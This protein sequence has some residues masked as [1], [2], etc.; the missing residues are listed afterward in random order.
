MK[1]IILTLVVVLYAMGLNAQGTSGNSQKKNDLP[2]I[3]DI[4]TFFGDP[5]ISGAQLS[6][7]GKY[8]S[9]RKPYNGIAN[10]W[11]KKID[12]PFESAK[13]V[14]A[15]IKRPVNSYFWSRD[16]K[17]ILYVQ[18]L[19][20]DENYRVYSVDPMASANPQ[21]GV[22]EAKDLTP[23]EKVRVYILSVPKTDP[24]NI[25]IGINDRDASYHDIYKL[26]IITGERK[27]ILQNNDKIAGFICD[28]EGVVRLAINTNE[29]G[30]QELLSYQNGK[31][32]KIY[33]TNSEE[34]FGFE[35]FLKDKNFGYLSSNKGDVD[36]TQ[37]Y[38][39]NLTNGQTTFMESDPESEVDLESIIFS[40]KEKK[41]IA[42]TY[43]G[44]RTRYYFKDSDWQNS[45]ETMKSKLP[46]G[47]VRPTSMTD[48]EMIWLVYVGSDV[49]PGSIYVFNRKTNEVSLLFNS[50]PELK[51]EYLANMEP[52]KFK[53]RDGVLIPGYIA[54]P[55][56][57]AAKN[58]PTVIFPHGG[59][60]ARDNWGFNVFVQFLAN[61]GYAVLVPNFR[62]STGYGKK[63][64]N[65]GNKQWGTGTMQHDLSDGVKYMIDRGIA[66]PQKVAIMG[67]SYGGYATLA[68]LA[69]TPE[70]YAAGVDI[71]G[72]SNLVTLLKT[73]PAYWE[74]FRKIMA[75]RLGDLNIPADVEQLKSQSPLFFA[76]NI[77]APLLVIQGANDPRVKQAE[78]DQIVSTLR[79]MNRQVEYMLAPDEG[80]GYQGKMNR[81]AMIAKIDMFLADILKGR[82]QDG[83]STEVTNKLNSLMVDIKN[84]KVNSD[85][86]N[87]LEKAKT[88]ALPE[89][90]LNKLKS[91]KLNFSMKMKV[92]GQDFN[93]TATRDLKVS[94]DG[95]IN[96]EDIATTP[97][98]N[99]KDSYL[100]DA[101]SVMPINT[102]KKF[103]DMEYLNL[104]YLIGGVKGTMKGQT[105]VKNID[106][107][108]SSPVLGDGASFET[109][110]SLL[111]FS[112]GYSAYLKYFDENGFTVKYSKV[113]V[114]GLEELTIGGSKYQCWK[115][116]ITDLEENSSNSYWISNDDI[117]KIIKSIVKM[118]ATMGGGEMTME[119]TGIN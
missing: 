5:K 106:E 28:D 56:G 80:H 15:D 110:L 64:L 107:K 7:D 24:Q 109:Y 35:G 21:T 4:E 63:F 54:T 2:P 96:I 36:L 117:P 17:Y 74:S 89:I 84:V 70:L 3:I 118:P 23:L 9:F 79:D 65:L 25:I 13:P 6:P 40:E 50:R 115:L 51:S 92:Q 66:N 42:T 55:K 33:E 75:I 41:L 38:T 27:L 14:T 62:G 10:I 86:G 98:G 20:G 58:L 46:D 67:G 119:L 116:K 114:L 45:F 39:I 52:I 76:K 26:N 101:N 68:G 48:D 104:S 113:E 73:I 31:F 108:F 111:K 83:Y 99:M 1:K 95:K 47:E 102:V 60:W 88:S 100:I 29:A 30:G 43:V 61:R 105:G 87:D 22:P 19:G 71:V 93:M 78:S 77:K 72:P 8:I 82:K 44:D 91:V 81:L 16:G 34:S 94:G 37:L 103:G 49:D 32:V 59:P 57:I 69:F 53:A 90:D 12:E 97:M 112:D 11:V 18:D 85:S